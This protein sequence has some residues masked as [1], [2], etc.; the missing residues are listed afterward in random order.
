MTAAVQLD[1]DLRPLH[2]HFLEVPLAHGPEVTPLGRRHPVGR[3][4]GLA[5][6]ELGVLGG[7]VV[8]D[9][10]LGH[11]RVGGVALAG[12]ADRQAVVA[13]GRELELDPGDEVAQ[14]LV[15]VDRAPL[16]GLAADGAVDDLVIGDRAFPAVGRLAVEDGLRIPRR[17]GRRGSCW[18]PPGGSRGG[19]CPSSGSRR[20]GSGAA[21][22]PRAKRGDLR[23]KKFSIDGVATT[24]LSLR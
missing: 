22:G 7:A 6:V 4:V 14:F 8:E 5:R 24:S 13:T 21:I 12:V 10:Q 15:V 23:S 19:R 16:A 9:L 18:P 3:A 17:P 1:L 20:R 11:P 2:A